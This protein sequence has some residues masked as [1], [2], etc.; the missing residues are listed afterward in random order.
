MEQLC[1]AAVIRL[2]MLHLL[3]HFYRRPILEEYE[4]YIGQHPVLEYIHNHPGCT[5]KEI[6]DEMMVTPASIALSTKRMQRAGL[7]HKDPNEN[8]LRCNMLY[9]TEKG[10]DIS[11]KC[12]QAFDTLDQKAFEG[13][14]EDEVQSLMGY[15]DRIATNLAGDERIVDRHTLLQLVQKVHAAKLSANARK[16]GEVRSLR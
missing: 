8:N 14:S 11:Q 15:L 4:L 6:A 1:H 10:T 12:R 2:E 16:D 3:R 7:I 5:Q 9:T 13:F